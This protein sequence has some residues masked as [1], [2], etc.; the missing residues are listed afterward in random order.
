MNPDNFLP[1][2]YAD[3]SGLII[4]AVEKAAIRYDPPG[5][6]PETE[7]E[8]KVVAGSIRETLRPFVGRLLAHHDVTR[9][10]EA[11]VWLRHL[12]LTAALLAEEGIEL[13][14]QAHHVLRHSP[15]A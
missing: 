2:E 12:N 11:G 4:V 15:A 9:S 5:S 3:V 10:I 14:T 7:D 1:L 6:A 8:R 13:R